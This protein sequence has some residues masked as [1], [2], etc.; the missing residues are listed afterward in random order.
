M[1][2]ESLSQINY[3]MSKASDPFA[4]KK[5]IADQFGLILPE[6][7]N[8]VAEKEYRRSQS[9]AVATPLESSPATSPHSPYFENTPP[10]IPM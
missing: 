1:L 8:M 3:I 7:A 9:P 2:K 5:K 4:I 10:R 6:Y